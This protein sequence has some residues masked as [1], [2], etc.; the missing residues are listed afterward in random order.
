MKKLSVATL[1]VMLTV[2][3]AFGALANV[4]TAKTNSPGPKGTGSLA[5]D[6]AGMTIP[7]PGSV[8][9]PTTGTFTIERFV[10]DG[11]NLI[12]VGTFTGTI[13]GAAAGPTPGSMVVTDPPGVCDILDLTLGPLHLDLLG[14]VVDLNQ[15]HLVITAQQGPGN[16]LGNLL[17]AVTGL[18]DNSGGIGGALNGI[19]ALLNQILGILNGLAV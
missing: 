10:N 18:L 13:N 17:C 2:A 6:G 7:A 4:A 9:V 1:G 11:T 16:L 3:V 12:A 5:V 19:T 15:V 8:A 14:L